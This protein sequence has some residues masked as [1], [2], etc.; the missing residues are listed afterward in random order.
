MDRFPDPLTSPGRSR[1]G[2]SFTA[3]ETGLFGFH[4]VAQ[5]FKRLRFNLVF[6]QREHLVFF[7][8]DVM[9]YIFHQH[10]DLRF[11]VL[12]GTG[13]SVELGKECLHLPVFLDTLAYNSFELGIAFFKK[14]R[15]KNG[16][17]DMGVSVQFFLDLYKGSFVVPVFIFADPGK[18]FIYNPVVRFEQIYRIWLGG[19]KDIRNRVYD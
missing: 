4:L 15:V 17:F 5:H 1:N 8:L 2:K 7:F 18:K 16:F 11:E 13:Q 14:V 6:D 3:S 10:L 12:G 9:L 19:F